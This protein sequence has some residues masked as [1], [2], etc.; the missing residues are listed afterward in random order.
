MTCF[1]WGM[2]SGA[3]LMVVGSVLGMLIVAVRSIVNE[4]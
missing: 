1:L 2:I 4:K 3:A